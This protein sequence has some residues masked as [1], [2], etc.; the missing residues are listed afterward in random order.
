MRIIHTADLHLDSSLSAHLST[1]K[2]E[3]RK[4]ELL[5]AFERLTIFAKAND[6][7]AVII[8]GYMFDKKHIPLKTRKKVFDYINDCKEIDFLYIQGNHDECDIDGTDKPENLK[9]FTNNWTFYS[10]GDVNIYGI[11]FSKNTNKYLYDTLLVDKDKVN[12]VALHGQIANH[13]ADDVINLNRLKEK[14]IDYLALGHIHQYSSEALDDR[15]IYCYSGCL[16]SR[17]FD[18]IGDKGFVL[19]DVNDKKLTHNFIKNSYRN[20]YQFDVDITDVDSWPKLKNK[21][22]DLLKEVTSNDMVKL[23]LKGHFK[24]DQQKYVF[25][26][27]NYLSNNYYFGKV[28]DE[29]KL[30]IDLKDYENE[31]SLKG[32]FIKEVKNTILDETLQ[33]DVILLGIKAL[34]EEDL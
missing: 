12:I 16:E 1:T 10:Y 23:V 19:I 14:G 28:K 8:A 7:K 4:K 34:T 15:G 11:N 22:S 24:V 29:S 31:K 17:G 13:N 26:L 9:L 32:E 27:E 5:N 20:M 18:E 25:E 3:Q 2:A 6:V 21:V 30:F 33:S